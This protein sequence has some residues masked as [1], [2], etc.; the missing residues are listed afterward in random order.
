MCLSSNHEIFSWGE[1]SLGRLGLG[2]GIDD[3]LVP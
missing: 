2:Q 3:I 1:S